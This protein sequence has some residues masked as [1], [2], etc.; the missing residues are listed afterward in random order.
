MS[1]K[2]F[3][4][5]VVFL[6]GLTSCSSQGNKNPQSNNR[7][8]NS[9][10]VGSDSKEMVNLNL[11]VGYLKR[12][13]EGDLD[14]ALEKFKKSISY[15]P[16]FALAHSMIANVYDKKGLFDSAEKHYKL[17]IKYNNGSPDILNNYANFLCQRGSYDLA[18]ENYLRVIQNPIYKSPASAYENAGVCAMRAK[19]SKNAENYFRQ[20]L[21]INN[22]QPNSLYYLM[23][24]QMENKKHLQALAFLQRLEQV[25]QSSSEMLAAGYKIEKA[26]NHSDLAEN[27]LKKLQRYYPNSESYKNLH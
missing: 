24:I 6:I 19:Q 23:L 22:K 15:N 7:T 9:N 20:S 27:Y 18:I 12:G 2:S 17:S 16:K 4:L 8:E 21:E 13:K 11:G 3:S 26:L 5:I 25:V 14:I 10:N 1:I